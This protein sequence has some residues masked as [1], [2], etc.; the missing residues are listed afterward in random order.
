MPQ[1]KLIKRFHN[2]AVRD[3]ECCHR[4]MR[5]CAAIDADSTRVPMKKSTLSRRGLLEAAVSGLC[6]KK[7]LSLAS[8]F[9]RA[10]GG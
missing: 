10:L 7:G 1:I 8:P 6:S 2:Y 3:G 9:S 4:T 5:T